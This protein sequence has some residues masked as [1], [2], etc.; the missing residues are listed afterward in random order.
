MQSRAAQVTPKAMPRGPW[1][2]RHEAGPSIGSVY[3]HFTSNEEI[4]TAI[5]DA[6]TREIT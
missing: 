1:S 6:V 5:A 3:A 4:V 2:G